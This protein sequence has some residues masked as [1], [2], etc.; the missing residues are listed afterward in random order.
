MSCFDFSVRPFADSDFEQCREIFIQSDPA[1]NAGILNSDS[2]LQVLQ[3]IVP[4]CCFSWLSFFQFF[5]VFFDFFFCRFFWFK[6]IY[7]VTLWL[8][9]Y[10]CKKHR[11]QVLQNIQSPIYTWLTGGGT[12][13][14]HRR[15]CSTITPDLQ[16]MWGDTDKT[17]THRN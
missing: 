9:K 7:L 11:K 16:F 10:K 2:K 5:K 15:S 6:Q 17:Q 4:G 14:V 8:K 12:Q 3:T 13:T 1:K